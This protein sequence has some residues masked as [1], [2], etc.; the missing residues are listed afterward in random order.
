[1]DYADYNGFKEKKTK[2]LP[3]LY[4]RYRNSVDIVIDGRNIYL[5][6]LSN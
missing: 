3:E 5:P 4:F 1:M 6:K 2:K